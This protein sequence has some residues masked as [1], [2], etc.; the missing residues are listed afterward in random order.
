[1]VPKKT[2]MQTECHSDMP[3]DAA[4]TRIMSPILA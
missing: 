1:M 2:V 3:N 4:I